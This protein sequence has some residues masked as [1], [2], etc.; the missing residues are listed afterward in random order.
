[1]S[2]E[3][4]SEYEKYKDMPNIKNKVH[5]KKINNGVIFLCSTLALTMFL[6]SSLGA[7]SA[8][9]EFNYTSEEIKIYIEENMNT[10]DD[11]M[12][13][14]AFYKTNNP[15]PLENKEIEMI[16]R[17]KIILDSPQYM[18]TEQEKNEEKSLYSLFDEYC[19]YYGLDTAK[20]FALAL[21]LT[22]GFESEKFL[23]GFVIGNTKF[24]Q[25]D[26]AY[27]TVEA[28]AIAF[29]RDLY[30][31]PENFGI[32]LNDFST[33]VY[34]NCS[35]YECLVGKVA[36]YC[37]LDK[38]TILA[39]MYLETGRFTS[40]AFE[41]YNNPAGI[42]L[43][44]GLKRFETKEHGIIEAIY[45]LYFNYY[46]DNPKADLYEV[47]FKYCPP[48]GD[49]GTGENYMWPKLVGEIREEIKSDSSIF[50]EG[51]K[52]SY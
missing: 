18:K 20:V 42:M 36:D 29:I 44:T 4:N 8:E 52:K 48:G 1:M 12:T 28:G 30:L 6:T 26:Y 19:G 23:N 37:T 51:T 34:E 14:D 27:P 2:L 25:C 7:T 11:F 46:K 15:N 45:N 9:K 43:S 35:S 31:E 17:E 38:N 21:N 40:S 13:S 10:L 47:G 24:Y 41:I 33:G 49:N 39:I 16:I 22:D 3:K 32:S 5:G 50:I